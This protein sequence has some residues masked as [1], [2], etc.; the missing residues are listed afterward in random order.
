[1]KL[2]TRVKRLEK[3][4]DRYKPLPKVLLVFEG[5][6]ETCESKYH[7]YLEQGGD[8]DAEI[9]YIIYRNPEGRPYT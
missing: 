7:E 8:P 4:F 9:Q 2:K 6:G 5:S 3:K 1:M